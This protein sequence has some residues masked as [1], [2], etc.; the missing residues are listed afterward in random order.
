MKAKSLPRRPLLACCLGLI[1]TGPACADAVTDWNITFNQLSPAVGGPP[2]WAYLGAMM[3]IAIHDALNSIDR[4]YQTYTVVGAAPAGAS[5]DA[6]IAAAARDVLINQL[7]RPPESPAKAS[8]RASVEARYAAALLAIPDGSAENQGVAA[9]RAAA[10][11]IIALR[12][13]D[14]SGAP[15]MPYTL[16]PGAGVYQPTAPNFPAPANAGFGRMKPFAMNSPSQFRASPGEIFDLTS[17][18]YARDYNQ[19][20]AVGERNTRASR[21]DSAETDIARFWPAGG[22]NWNLVTRTIVAS[23]GLNRWQHARLFALLLMGETDGAISVFD[24]KYAYNFWRPVTA[25]RWGNDGNPATVSDPGWLPFFSSPGAWSTPPYPDYTCGLT[26]TG[27]ATTE[28]LRRYF[29]TDRVAYTLTVKAPAMDAMIPEK[30]ITRHFD[31]LSQAAAESAMARVYAGI[32]FRSGCVRGIT[33][34]EQVG[35]FAIQHYL[36]PLKP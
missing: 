34:G 24:T 30:D 29:G 36:K 20:K 14:G 10:N 26:T 8:A 15:N 9:G 16:A 11:A 3:H 32:H 6:A 22:A 31:S 17:A 1:V 7:S 35:R 25:I 18:A 12:L 27:G 4:R 13:G 21:L 23:R 2:Q 33:Q 28:V 5:A 19:V